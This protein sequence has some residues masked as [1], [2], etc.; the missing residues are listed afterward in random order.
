[1]Q[2]DMTRII[3]WTIVGIVVVLGVIFTVWSRRQAAQMKA[4]Y[5]VSDQAYEQFILR[6]EQRIENLKM[7]AGRAKAKITTPSPDIQ[8]IIDELDAK[9]IQLETTVSESKGITGEKQREEACKNISQLF[10]EARKLIRNIG[11][12]VSTPV[13]GD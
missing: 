12:S 6:Y 4:S 5:P 2:K 7:R 10:R 3:V 13:S 9:M 8:A 11:G 1:M